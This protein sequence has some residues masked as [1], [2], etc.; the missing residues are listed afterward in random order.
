MKKIIV[1]IIYSLKDMHYYF[2]KLGSKYFYRY[3]VRKYYIKKGDNLQSDEVKKIKDYWHKY[4][5]DFDIS[6][7]KY[8]INRTGKFD[9]RYIPDDL[10]ASKID[11]YFNNRELHIGVC[12]KNYFDMW[13]KDANMPKTIVRIINGV[14]FNKNYKIISK[15]EAINLLA[16]KDS[17]VAKPCLGS[18]GGANVAFY[19][20]KDKGQIEKI[21]EELPANNMIFQE[22]I[23]QHKILSEIHKSSVNSL[24]IMT[25][26]INNKIYYL[27]GVLRMGI[28]DSKVDNAMSGGIYCGINPDGS[29][30]DKAFD[31]Y[32]NEFSKHP[33]GYV[34]KNTVIPG[35]EKAIE[36]VKREAEKMAHFRLISWD[37]AIDE[38]AEPVLIEANLQ[39]GDI[40]ILQPVNGPLFGE[41]TDDVLKEV[42][43]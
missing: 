11:P 7:H 33:Q 23:K 36:M 31:L 13:F 1:K 17:F 26:Q 40:D 5:K 32:G 41:L 10:Y 6:Y 29:L 34:F 39:M 42:F 15:K 43:K 28:G 22:T 37:V 9:V 12:D 20:N 27:Q 25:L 38:N 4:T 18:C 24:R 16:N 3:K 21:L 2:M 8:Y 35:Y 19:E 14:F 30:K